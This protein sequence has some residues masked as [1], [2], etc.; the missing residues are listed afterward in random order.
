MGTEG[1]TDGNKAPENICYPTKFSKCEETA[2]SKRRKAAG[3]VGDKRLLTKPVGLAIS[4][5]GIR[6]AT[7]G[8]GVVQGLARAG[9]LRRIDYL[10]TVSGGGFIGSFLGRLFLRQ[11]IRVPRAGDAQPAEG[12]V[13]GHAL[14]G[15]TVAERVEEVLRDSSRKP[16]DWLRENGRY[17]S[18]NGA[19]DLLLAFSAVL[20]N[21][22]AI[23]IVLATFVL[24]ILLLLQGLRLILPRAG[25]S[26]W[27]WPFR[28]GEGPIWWSELAILPL[29]ALVFFAI[30]LGW[31]YWLGQRGRKPGDGPW[32]KLV[33]A[34]TPFFLVT[35]LW[36]ASGRWGMRSLY[37]DEVAAVL[38]AVI[39]LYGI[40]LVYVVIARR[41][42]ETL[43]GDGRN[44]PSAV[45]KIRNNKLTQWLRTTLFLTGLAFLIVLVD[46][47]GQTLYA[48]LQSHA[49]D[50]SSTLSD[51]KTRVALGVLAGVLLLG[52][53]LATF[54]AERSGQSRLNV[55]SDVLAT[56]AAAVLI[57]AVLVT[58]SV[59]SHAL[60]ANFGSPEGMPPGELT[61]SSPSGTRVQ[62]S[63]EGPVPFVVA[64][65]AHRPRQTGPEAPGSSSHRLFL[66]SLVCGVL[67]TFIF[68]RIL[69]F[70]NQSSHQVLDAAR[71]TRAYM[72][73]SNPSRWSG[74]HS[75]IT[76]PL[77]G[78]GIGFEE[79]KPHEQGGPLHL[80]NVTVNET[81]SGRSQVEQRD[82]KGLG[83]AIG[84]IGVS[85]GAKHHAT[86]NWAKK[87][88]SKK[89]NVHGTLELLSTS[90][91]EKGAFKVFPAKETITPEVLDVGTW[92]SI[93][94]AAVST[95]MGARTS[96]GLSLLC[97]F[98]NVRLGYWW[99]S[100]VEP[101]WRADF[102]AS[103]R[104]GGKIKAL[105]DRVL[106]VQMHLLDEFLARFHGPARRLWYLSD[107]GHFENTGVYEL[108]R[109]RLPLI[110]VCDNGADP[111]YRFN[112]LAGLVRKARLDF[113]TEIDFLDG[114]ALA[115]ENL[116]AKLF[117]SLDQLRL[118]GNSKDATKPR[119]A[120]RHAAVA[121]VLYP[122]SKRGAMIVLKPTV[123]GDEPADV[124]E[125]AARSGAFPQE[126]TS[127]QY[128]DE[129]QWESYR[130]LGEVTVAR[131]AEVIFKRFDENRGAFLV[132]QAEK[133]ES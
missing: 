18:P 51:V 20:R 13:E 112:D 54:L 67:F 74:K 95:G 96:L 88:K 2:I 14:S 61:S 58:L 71:L 16:I 89:T 85:V 53:K 80:I 64:V 114:P 56:I 120:E 35:L 91:D 132:T 75:W 26:A 37:H 111:E 123:T 104:I 29:V 27:F 40:A 133:A 25:R 101:G 70:V 52:R 41:L 55:P 124:L 66:W 99:D 8:L 48:S 81:L 62:V 4:G 24:T 115:R 23:H 60:T 30:P 116:D 43:A 109:R 42:A 77:P 106:P 59:I 72:G 84:P 126:P 125:Y 65:Q 17:L 82:R 118:P 94:G 5:G 98:F 11:W 103:P 46:S 57:L 15:D 38:T 130:K 108:I 129:A 44:E 113:G 28:P 78:D 90:D 21:W 50:I 128:F 76:E 102:P 69:P 127:D 6:S 87:E 32:P 83:M 31:A 110:L 100:G 107:G 49:F 131:L 73:A 1:S 92:I 93:S 7:F 39:V 79:Y 86:W 9:V 22:V 63:A 122:D 45:D 68:G 121:R 47:L 97:G 3:F 10:S 19:G 34:G 36:V 117:G 119:R 105:L 12:R 33:W